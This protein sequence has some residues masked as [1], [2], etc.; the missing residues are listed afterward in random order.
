M[1]KSDMYADH[2]SDADTGYDTCSDCDADVAIEDLYVAVTNVI[3]HLVNGV[4]LGTE[5]R[6]LI[7]EYHAR[8]GDCPCSSSSSNDADWYHVQL[9]IAVLESYYGPEYTLVFV[10][11]F[12]GPGWGTTPTQAQLSMMFPDERVPYQVQYRLL[13]QG[14]MEH[15]PS[16]ESI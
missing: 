1:T 13:Q 3:D 11:D 14:V 6:T 10:A 9:F 8:H 2:D 5:F 12:P 15:L 16:L 4:P 7:D